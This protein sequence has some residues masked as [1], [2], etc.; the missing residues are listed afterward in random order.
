[1]PSRHFPGR[2]EEKHGNLSRNTR[3]PGQD[4]ILETPEHK[5]DVLAPT[6]QTQA[7]RQ[8]V[9]GKNWVRGH[10]HRI[11]PCSVNVRPDLL[12]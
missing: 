6:L 2:H 5:V 11:S 8:R 12:P 4:Y 10:K 7:R 3:Y 9:V 1:M